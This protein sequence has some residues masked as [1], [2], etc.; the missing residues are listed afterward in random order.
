MRHGLQPHTS[1]RK[2][3]S[4]HQGSWRAIA[5]QTANFRRAGPDALLQEA[6]WQ[7]L[8]LVKLRN[9]AAAAEELA[10]LGD[11]DSPDYMADTPEGARHLT[12]QRLLSSWHPTRSDLSV[13]TLP[14]QL[15]LIFTLTLLLTNPASATPHFSTP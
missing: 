3:M 9:F 13:K 14:L 1:T 4:S 8:A 2:A 7:V 10:A 15:L 11:L 12:G 5:Q 6:A